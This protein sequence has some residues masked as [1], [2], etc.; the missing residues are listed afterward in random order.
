[1]KLWCHT[2]GMKTKL[3][4]TTATLLLG[5][6]LVGCS[7]SSGDPVGRDVVAP[8]TMGVNELQGE[9]VE[10]IVGQVLNINTES[11]AVDSY[12]GEVVDTAVAEFTPGRIDSSAEFNPG[13][14]ALKTGETTVVMT[15]EQGGIQ[16]LEFTVVV[17][18]KSS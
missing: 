14:K 6:A 1:M 3:W 17:V 5:M 8:V 18:P 13:V 4:A 10:L 11:L 16:P 9:R 15:N 2:D 12:T 7:G